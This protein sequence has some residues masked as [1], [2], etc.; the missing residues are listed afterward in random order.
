MCIYIYIYI[1]I[2]MHTCIYLF[3]Y[4]EKTLDP[5]GKKHISRPE[6]EIFE[7]RPAGDETKDCFEGLSV[8]GFATARVPGV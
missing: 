6:E 7:T 3:V 8:Q 4:M 5:T 2:Y 1:Y